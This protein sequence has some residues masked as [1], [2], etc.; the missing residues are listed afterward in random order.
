MDR[1]KS[2]IS[3]ISSAQDDSWIDS[4]IMT[5]A[6]ALQ[7]LF[8]DNDLGLDITIPRL[9]SVGAQSSAKS[10]ALN[11]ICKHDILPTASTCCTRVVSVVQMV[12][13]PNKNSVSFFTTHNGELSLKK[14]TSLNDATQVANDIGYF[15]NLLAGS[16]KGMS[17]QTLTIRINSPNVPNIAISDCP[18]IVQR[19][20][21]DSGQPV[22]VKQQIKDLI[23]HH[24]SDP[25]AIIVAVMP[26]RPD[27]ETD[28][29][30]EVLSECDPDFSRTIG[31]LSK[32]DLVP[33]G[34]EC[35]QNYLLNQNVS[36][37]LMPAHGYFAVKLGG[38]PLLSHAERLNDE[39]SFFTSLP[40]HKAFAHRTGVDN[41]TKALSQ[42]LKSKLEETM[43]SV[44]DEVDAALTATNQEIQELGGDLPQSQEA[45]KLYLDN[46]IAKIS[47][48]FVNNLERGVTL[49]NYGRKLKEIFVEYR[50][51]ILDH[52]FV[53]DIDDNYLKEAIQNSHGNRMATSFP[54]VEILESIVLDTRKDVL[55]KF[56]NPTDEL[57][58]RVKA[59]LLELLDDILDSKCGR[60]QNLVKE[61]NITVTKELNGYADRARNRVR[62]AVGI[63]AAYVWAT[64][65]EFLA[66]LEEKSMKAM[67]DPGT[68][69]KIVEGYIH[70]VKVSL[71][72]QLPKLVMYFLVKRIEGKLHHHLT[73]IINQPGGG[74][75]EKWLDEDHEVVKQ[76]NALLSKQKALV[77]AQKILRSD[78]VS[79]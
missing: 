20:C 65:E 19:G 64:D 10:S 22:D 51:E 39:R 46:L 33:A 7:S 15:T 18:G 78:K 50:A 21:T 8:S 60:F 70:T 49:L 75:F 43:P 9:V 5:K 16:Q 47:S 35:L 6:N 72:N 14:T 56:L 48:E 34:S 36:K 63:E 76:R 24:I 55:C 32:P 44:S 40:N 29:V 66:M 68:M 71:N 74:L 4:E 23:T 25:S 53:S 31:I 28:P 77:E 3:Y 37:D 79:D 13:D 38:N 1:L 42:I 27:L 73:S 17:K 61:I 54:T 57:I 45:Q 69:R 58:E 59:L 62:E 30:F 2:V 52:D 11:A 67:G 41:L 12:N 26:L